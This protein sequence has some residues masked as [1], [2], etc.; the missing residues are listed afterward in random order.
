MQIVAFPIGL[1]ICVVVG[2]IA[3]FCLPPGLRLNDRESVE[4]FL[5]LP[6]LV[7]VI[8][9]IPVHELTHAL[10]HPACGLS[11]KTIIG[12]WL[13]KGLFYAYYEGPMTRNRFLMVYAGPFVVLSLLIRCQDIV[14]KPCIQDIV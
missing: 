4:L 10:F 7:I 5:L 8:F 1:M 6:F 11:D 3:L 9:L 14:H 12:L 2:G 13:S